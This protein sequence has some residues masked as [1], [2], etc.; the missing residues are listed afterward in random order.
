MPEGSL[1]MQSFNVTVTNSV[2]DEKFLQIAGEYGCKN[3]ILKRF[4]E[5]LTKIKG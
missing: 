3:T 1:Q 5:W 4:D 2:S